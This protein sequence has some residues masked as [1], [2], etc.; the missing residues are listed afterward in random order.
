MEKIIYQ[1][2]RPFQYLL[3]KQKS[4]PLY[5]WFF[6]SVL[7]GISFLLFIPLGISLEDLIK[8]DTGLLS[9]L[10]SFLQILPGFYIAALAAIAVF[11]KDDIDQAM[12][13][14]TPLMDVATKEGKQ[15]IRL[16]RRRFLCMLFAFLTMESIAL[17]IF[18]SIGNVATVPNKNYLVAG[19]IYAG[20]FLL[21]FW[22]LVVSTSF[23]LYYLG[24]RLHQ[25]DI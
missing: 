15:K 3:I 10:L 21:L 4:K 22:Q 13:E 8:A 17:I 23:G 24:D 19:Y 6:P 11:N 2:T 7:T 20:S 14:P 25:P 5:D 9:R 12:P 1:L 18:V 16:T